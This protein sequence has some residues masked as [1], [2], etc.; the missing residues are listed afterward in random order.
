LT[1]SDRIP[2]DRPPA[3]RHEAIPYER[4]PGYATRYR[5]RR[6]Q[7]AS[8]PRT[9]RRERDAIARLLATADARPGGRWLDVP[10]GAGRLCDLLPAGAEGRLVLADRDPAMVAAAAGVH[11]D[12]RIVADA[13]A[14]PFAD[15]TFDGVL[16]MRLLQHAPDERAR[17]AVL[18]ELA[19]VARE[20]V[21]FSFF[22][23]WCFQHVRRLVARKLYKP[24]SGRHAI[25]LAR[26][27]REARMAGLEIRAAIGLSPGISEQWIVLARPVRRDG[28]REDHG[29]A[30][31]SIA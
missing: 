23:S 5:D 17:T 9:G 13:T 29:K 20:H 19:R 25:S 8:G 26:M 11:A 7:E 4:E 24:R 27:R 31:A 18:R 2:A 1:P 12:L 22:H 30:R 6:F 14:L 3:E 15:A 16:C 28:E 21:V 10:S